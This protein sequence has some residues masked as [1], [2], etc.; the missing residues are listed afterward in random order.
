MATNLEKIRYVAVKTQIQALLG[1]YYS[2]TQRD[3]DVKQIGKL[4]YDT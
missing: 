3:L 4:C 1:V 2:Q